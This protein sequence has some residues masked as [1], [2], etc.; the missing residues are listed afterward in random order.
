MA[1]SRRD[2]DGRTSYQ[3]LLALVERMPIL[4]YAVKHLAE[5]ISIVPFSASTSRIISSRLT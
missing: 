5:S 1:L 3:E 2:R 4:N